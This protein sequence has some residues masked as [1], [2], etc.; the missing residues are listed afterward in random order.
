MIHPKGTGAFQPKYSGKL[1][2]RGLFIAHPGFFSYLHQARL[3]VKGGEFTLGL[4]WDLILK[5]EGLWGQLITA[6]CFDIGFP[7]GY[8]LCRNQPWNTLPLS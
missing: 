6:T 4:V 3:E 7:E 2:S 5:E 8:L 1:R